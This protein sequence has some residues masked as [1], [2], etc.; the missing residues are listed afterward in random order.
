MKY[1]AVDPSYANRA[2]WATYDT[3][4]CEWEWGSYEVDGLNFKVR[5][6]N[7]FNSLSRN[8]GKP[9]HLIL[10]WPT[11]Y[12]G[13]R[14]QI[15]AAKS[16]TINLAGIVMFVVGAFAMPAKDYTLYTAP[17]WK[18]SVSKQVTARRFFKMFKVELNQVDHDTID[19][20]MMLVYHLQL[21]GELP[22]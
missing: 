10:E 22:K 14:G 7:L 3:S 18:G 13:E 15:A 1:L 21:I 11:Y 4:T 6:W 9:D 2:G 20:V 16:Y 8:Q 19:A 5:C 12:G 17:D